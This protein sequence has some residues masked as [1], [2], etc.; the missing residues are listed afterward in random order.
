MQLESLPHHHPFIFTSPRLIGRGT[1]H[2]LP[3]RACALPTWPLALSK[4]KA[5]AVKGENGCGDAMNNLPD[6]QL[7]RTLL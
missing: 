3:A 6:S 7:E 1:G 2:C 4:P 5:Y